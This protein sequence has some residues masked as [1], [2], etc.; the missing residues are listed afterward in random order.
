MNIWFCNLKPKCL[1]G[2]DWYGI[3][4][5]WELFFYASLAKLIAAAKKL[6]FTCV[7]HRFTIEWCSWN[8]HATWNKIRLNLIFLRT[9]LRRFLRFIRFL[10]IQSSTVMKRRSWYDINA[11]RYHIFQNLFRFVSFTFRQKISLR[12]NLWC[13]WR[14]IWTKIRWYFIL[15]SFWKQSVFQILYL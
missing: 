9:I 3:N 6:W 1:P 8:V 7:F 10:F 2:S 5:S 13:S 12:N 4:F 15:A 11:A 14:I